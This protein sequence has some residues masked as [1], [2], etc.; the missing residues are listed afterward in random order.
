MNPKE[1]AE[2]ILSILDIKKKEDIDI[3]SIS[4]FFDIC[5]VKRNLT[6]CSARLICSKRSA[7]ITISNAEKY[8]PRVRFSIAHELGH[9]FLHKTQKACFSCSTQDMS[10]WEHH[11]IEVEANA[12]AANILMPEQIFRKYLLNKTPSVDLVLTTSNDFSTSLTAT[13][14]RYVECSFEPLALIYL[15]DGVIS[16]SKCNKDFTYFLKRAGSPVHEHSYATDCFQKRKSGIEG[17]VPA[18]AWL[19]DYKVDVDSMIHEMAF[20][21]PTLNAAQSLLWIDG[22]IEKYQ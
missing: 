3:D 9:F 16:W 20:Y 7:R 6:G 2:Y 1:K 5:V 14:I 18:Y 13:L 8:E 11:S 10:Q 15:K 4:H 19:D 17:K 22:D 21:S 12:F